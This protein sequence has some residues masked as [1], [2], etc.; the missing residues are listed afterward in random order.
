M[1][2]LIRF[3]D[4]VYGPEKKQLILDSDVFLMPSRFEGH[5]MALV[6]ALSYGVPCLVTPGSNMMDEIQEKNAGWTSECSINGIANALTEAIMSPT[7]VYMTKGQNARELA[8]RYEWVKL[9]EDSHSG[10]EALLR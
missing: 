8:G 9:A 10:Y 4:G 7:D 6:E 1:D 5:P 2:G 3:H